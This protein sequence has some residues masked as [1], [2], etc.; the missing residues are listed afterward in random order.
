VQQ[1]DKQVVLDEPYAA[2]KQ[3][4]FGPSAYK[5][6][7]EEV[8]ALA[9]PA[10]A[11]Q[12]ARPIKF[13]LYFVEGKEEFTDES[14]AMVNT[15]FAEIASRP[16]PDIVVVGHTDSTG[17]DQVNDARRFGEGPA[18]ATRRGGGQ[19]RSDLARQARS[20]R[21]HRE[22]RFRSAQPSRRNHRP[23]TRSPG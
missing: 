21:R 3:G 1:G 22:R 6:T 4:V 15:V 7:P 13:T 17:T 19:R 5:A 14:K 12:P 9:G 16:V 8:Q 2:S 20:R 10:L 18:R 11:A 23:L